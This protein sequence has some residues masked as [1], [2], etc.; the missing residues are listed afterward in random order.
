[1]EETI[2]QRLLACESRIQRMRLIVGA[3]TT[4]L[5][6]AV[7][8]L[9]WSCASAGPRHTDRLSLLRV[10]ELVVVDRKGVER[11]RIG[12]DLPSATEILTACNQ[13][14]REDWCRTCLSPP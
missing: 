9:L 14:R 6:L 7:L 2:R 3:Q 13:R 4:L 10:S 5:L 12:G 1:M 8:A 11:V